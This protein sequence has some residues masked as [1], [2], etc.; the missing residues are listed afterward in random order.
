MTRR[1]TVVL[2]LISVALMGATT[3]SAESSRVTRKANLVPSHVARPMASARL[4][5]LLR[6]LEGFAHQELAQALHDFGATKSEMS[7]V[8][9]LSRRRHHEKAMITI[10]VHPP[11]CIEYSEQITAEYVPVTVNGVR[12][13]ERVQFNTFETGGGDFPCKR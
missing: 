7:E 13:G 12:A 3:A 11:K 10:Y 1:I 9:V 5:F 4:K 8:S 2:L 6:Q